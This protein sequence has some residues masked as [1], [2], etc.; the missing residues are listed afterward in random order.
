LAQSVA[1]L[2]TDQPMPLLALLF[3]LLLVL[4]A[5]SLPEDSLTT[6]D[7]CVGDGACTLNAL[8]L[9]AKTASRTR[10]DELAEH[11]KP[12]KVIT[13]LTYHQRHL[14]H[15]NLTKFQIE[16][17][18]YWKAISNLS[19][20]VNATKE[21]V[22]KCVYGMSGKPAEDGEKENSVTDDNDDDDA[23]E[24][25]DDVDW[26]FPTGVSLIEDPEDEPGRR[27]RRWHMPRRVGKTRGEIDYEYKELKV[28]WD[29]FTY[30]RHSC[31]YVKQ[32]MDRN[33]LP[34]VKKDLTDFDVPDSLKDP[35]ADGTADGMPN[36]EDPDEEDDEDEDN[37]E[38][39]ESS[40]AEASGSG[41]PSK[42]TSGSTSG[43][44]S[45][46]PAV[47]Y[48]HRRRRR[49]VPDYNTLKK[50]ANTVD[51]Q[52]LEVKEQME[53]IEGVVD[54]AADAVEA[55]CKAKKEMAESSTTQS[56]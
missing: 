21:K 30:I 32:L 13:D 45:A 47:H 41:A 48:H 8:Q 42:E 54:S 12:H 19:A 24:G 31:V 52:L 44:S 6:D 49:S 50:D 20:S 15:L 3:G 55:Y 11:E 38:G 2:S 5:G 27:R 40:D 22:D 28:F 4:T 14:L 35:E 43:S 16:I 34:K 17:V 9:Q 36:F 39:G 46:K 53:E 51:T 10:S 56:P 26:H 18:H 25:D 33:R 29:T 7:E 1:V 23:T 37:D